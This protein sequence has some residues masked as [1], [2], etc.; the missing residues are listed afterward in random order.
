MGRTRLAHLSQ[1]APR[2]TKTR[3]IR[4]QGRLVLLR[5]D[6]ICEARSEPIAARIAECLRAC[7]GLETNERRPEATDTG[8]VRRILACGDRL[9]AV[10]SAAFEKPAIST[11][12]R[13]VL[14]SALGAWWQERG[15][16]VSADRGRRTDPILNEVEPVE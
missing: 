10:A 1:V 5:D 12:L 3:R 2:G 8:T 9:S 7:A 4:A 6:L 11:A 15:N 14:R 16:F 13:G